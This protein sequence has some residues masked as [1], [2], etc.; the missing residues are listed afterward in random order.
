M[1]SAAADA[2][3][4]FKVLCERVVGMREALD[5]S[6]PRDAMERRCARLQRQID[7]SHAALRRR[8]ARMAEISTERDELRAEVDSMRKRLMP[9]GM[10]WPKVDGKPVDFK[11]AY[12]PS[13]GVLEAVSIYNNGACEVMSHDGIV[14]N[15][16]E[17]HV[18]KPKVVDADGVEIKPG[19]TV[20][21]T[22]DMEPMRVVDTDSD[23]C[24]FKKI[25]C[26]KEGDGFW[27]YCPD[28]LTHKLP[29]LAADGEP[30]EV[31]QTVYVIATGKTHHVTE[32]DAVS[33][34]FRSMEQVDG[35][36]W[37]DPM[38]FTH[39][40]PVLDA[41]GV[42]IKVGETVYEVGENYPPFIVGRLPEPG[43]YRSV[44]VVDPNG[45]F[46][47]LDPERLT[48]AKPEP[49]DSIEKVASDL[50]KMAE[51]WCSKPLLK[52][53]QSCAAAQVG[54]LT[55]GDALKSV[56]RRCWALA[57]RGE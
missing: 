45:A 36:H 10:E 41:D 7:E 34:H 11:T 55:L 26:E 40:R 13:L 21:G 42:P 23:E 54:E 57:E 30:L 31:G 12:E 24:G 19:D 5:R 16:T 56:S 8:N 46:T 43:A 22:R 39:K 9:K 2:M 27:F 1:E 49:P 48:H 51:V 38:C 28:E 50:M 33:K 3:E 44:R 14:K 25:K 47:Y 6:V 35:S 53:A 32:V 29:V 52:D 20:C 18:F 37:L 4:F 17:I 15:A